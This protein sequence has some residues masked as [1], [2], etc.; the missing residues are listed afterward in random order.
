MYKNYTKIFCTPNTYVQ[1]LL[2]IMKLA[3]L[4]LFLSLMQVSAATFGQN[5]TLREKNIS[6]AK[7]FFEIRKQTGFNV[8][9]ESSEFKTSKKI[10]AN[11]NNSNIETVMKQVISETELIYIIEEKTIVVKEKEK[12]TF[13][14]KVKD[15]FT[16]I[17]VSGRVVDEK[18][19]P[20][21]GATIRIKGTN[22]SVSANDKGEF[23][24]KNVAEDA[25][26][27]IGFVGF[28]WKEVKVAKELGEIKLRI[29]VGNLDEVSV[30][31]TGYQTLPK[32]RS[33]GSFTVIDNKTIN[34]SIG[35]NILDR[36]D[37][38][39]SGLIFNP[40]L[41]GNSSKISIHGRSTIFAKADPLIVLDGF[42]YE[43]TIDQINP[44]DIESINLLKDAAASSIW[45]ARSGNGVIVISTK[46]GGQNR[47]LN[48]G[49]SSTLT[50]GSKP[51][52]YYR[53]QM[54]SS[55][56][57]DLEQYLFSRGAYNFLFD[58]AYSAVS[59]AVEI[60]NQRKLGKLN[61]IDSASKINNLKNQDVRS[62]IVQ[63]LFKPKVQQQYQLNFSG[64][65][66]N[67]AFYLSGGYDKNLDNAVS[68]AF[69]R[70]TLNASNTFF[71]LKN[72]L[73]ISGDISYVSSTTNIGNSYNPL[74][75]YDKI[76]DDLGNSLPVVFSAQGLRNSYVDTVGNGKLLDWH[77]RPKDELKSNFESRND[78]VRYKFGINYKII[79]SLNVSVNYQLLNERIDDQLNNNQNSFYT[80]DLINQFSYINGNIVNRVIPTGDILTENLRKV[81]SKIFRGQINYEKV[82]SAVHEINA[83]AGYEGSDARNFINQ[84]T[85]YGYDDDTRINANGTIN[86]LN[87]Y[88]WYYGTNSSTISTSP[89]LYS[90]TSINQSFYF[91]ASYIFKQRYILSGSA[92]RDESNLF[93]VKTNQK[94]VPLWSAG[95]A[96]SVDH[97][98]FFRINW[99]SK[100]KLR[101]TYGINGNI[102]NTLSAYFT[103]I[104]NGSTQ[105]LFGH[106]ASNVRNPPNPSLR[107]EKIKTLNLGIDFALN[108]NRISGSIDWYVKKSIDLIGNNQI[109]A[110]SG[111]LQ[112][113]G[114]G[115]NLATR[116]VD[117]LFN[118]RNL[119]SSLKWNTNF[120]FS[121]NADKV[122]S[123]NIKQSSNLNIISGNTQNP[124]EGY[125]YYAI[126]SFP[127]AGLDSR[128]APQGYLNGIISKDYA[129]IR[130]TL[131]PSQ[132]KFHG[133]ASPKYFGSVINTFEF[134]NFELSVNITYKFDY[135][136]RRTSVFAGGNYGSAPFLNYRLAEFENRW[137]NPGDE[138]KT[139]IP[140]LIYPSNLAQ[141]SFFEN[142]EDLIENGDHIRLQ[143]VRLSYNLKSLGTASKIFK[144]ATIFLYAR[145][146]GVVWKKT[147]FSIDPDARSTGIPAVFNGS[148]GVNLNL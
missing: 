110:Q 90:T 9:V 49:A 57:I 113:K 145:N 1:K 12:P 141:Y 105:N 68:N 92:R 122:T 66:D 132:I 100:L 62:D 58:N 139:K 121:Y 119:T 39:S 137:K 23:L 29:F 107:W 130:S 20:L 69:D 81:S 32:E 77:Y 47:K 54:S 109:A 88:K 25:V 76:V 7:L 43:G 134:K 50:I 31:N 40:A 118:S 87:S 56:L 65:S 53:D 10:D 24:L 117:F 21:A 98:G 99:L 135:Y 108:Q 22:I 144:S 41:G 82:F 19:L 125:P 38:V 67:H 60:F 120:L 51:D 115:A 34:R 18:G 28:Q 61:S 2:F 129:R 124:L 52:L 142:S 79:P 78:Q 146:L 11:F 123:Y 73:Q 6:Y 86:P 95:L 147:S 14:Q 27:E 83:I 55:D 143:D 16:N 64:G 3:T 48:I 33:T 126:F 91:N 111:I 8:L 97:E 96:W 37:G 13:I 71:L 103:T 26:L 84:Q 102:D 42:P 17:D 128:G 15:Y 36:L 138:L 94:G 112:F 72:R 133:S 44:A 59:E 106:P 45:G 35:T 136:F 85:Y 5:L 101:S 93:G 114:N 46:R 104:S 131:D 70:I 148:F 127:S 116:G 4:L 75:S 30:V 74:S 89:N 80:R 63:Y 140:A